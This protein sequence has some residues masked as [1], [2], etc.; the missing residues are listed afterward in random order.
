MLEEMCRKFIRISLH[1]RSDAPASQVNAAKQYAL[2]GLLRE[3]QKSTLLNKEWKSSEVMAS[4]SSTSKSVSTNFE[5]LDVRFSPYLGQA[6][7]TIPHSWSAILLHRND[8]KKC[9]KNSYPDCLLFPF[10]SYSSESLRISYQGFSIKSNRESRLD[11]FT[12]NIFY[13][14][15]SQKFTKD[16]RFLSP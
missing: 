8:D 7:N 6:E 13:L 10:I 16:S 9:L 1:H 15:Q 12:D 4:T 14:N 5:K 11:S 2:L 3:I